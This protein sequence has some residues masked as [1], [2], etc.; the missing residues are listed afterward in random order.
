MN[1]RILRRA[2]TLA[3][4]LVVI[5]IIVILVA[6]TLPIA[7]RIMDDSRTRDSA[8]MLAG[9]FAMAR[10]HAARN[11]RPFGLWLQLAP[12][13]AVP[14][15]TVPPRNIRQCTQ[16][17]L[18]EV[19]A[20]YA[21]DVLMTSG[22]YVT[23]PPVAGPTPTPN[24]AGPWQLAFAGAS[25][26]DS[27]IGVNEVFR[28]R[29]D[30]QGHQYLGYRDGNTP[31]NY[32]VYGLAGPD[33]QWGKQGQDDDGDGST[34]NLN[35]DSNGDGTPDRSGE[36]LGGGSDDLQMPI[37][38]HILQGSPQPPIFHP[39]QIL[40]LP[41]RVGNPIEL[42]AGTCI[43]LEYCGMGTQ[44]TEFAATT[45]HLVV[46][47]SPKGEIDGLIGDTTLAG[48][49]GTLHFLIGQVDKMNEPNAVN[50]AFGRN[51]F[52]PASSNLSD[53]NSVWVSIG[54]QNGQVTT[55]ENLVPPVLVDTTSTPPTLI[56]VFPGEAPPPVG[57]RQPLMVSNGTH[58]AIYLSHCRE[59]AT[60]R[61]QMGGK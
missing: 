49:T 19:Q 42:V 15:T 59:V 10:T 46:L 17:F 27:L 18:A 34:D 57:R 2:Y 13:S 6:A 20:P 25:M 5:T 11:N 58:Q 54:R 24:L 14:D 30:Y 22:A 32:Y 26:L 8:R 39:F 56:T 28:I 16:V 44:G 47:F 31:G 43:D 48:P 1:Q 36:Y 3:E 52:D 51:L 53:V 45:D 60:S 41:R 29:F 35:I 50:T 37:P 61:E 33:G 38:P 40:R 9:N 55:T 4:L 23:I 7:K 21:G 12:V